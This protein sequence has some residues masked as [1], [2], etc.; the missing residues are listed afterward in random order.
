MSAGGGFIVGG[1]NYGQGSSREHAAIVPRHLGII[2]VI[3]KSYARIHRKNLINMGIMP[4]IFKSDG[5]YEQMN[6]GDRVEIKDILEGVEEGQ[7]D[8]RI[9][10]AGSEAGTLIALLP[11]LK[12]EREILRAGGALNF[13]RAARAVD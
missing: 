8:V 10:R 12:K 6:Q 11:L 2:A 5:D 3:A 13:A 9:T 4:F 1:H 7:L